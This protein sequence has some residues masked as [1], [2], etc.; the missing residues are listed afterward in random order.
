[1]GCL[2]KSDG[3]KVQELRVLMFGENIQGYQDF[4]AGNFLPH[5]TFMGLCRDNPG[6]L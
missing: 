3:C 5:R 1:M 2:M 6:I 4:T